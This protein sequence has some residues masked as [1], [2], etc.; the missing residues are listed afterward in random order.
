MKTGKTRYIAIRE[1][2]YCRVIDT[3]ENKLVK[4]FFNSDKY[5]FVNAVLMADELN[6][7][8]RK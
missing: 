6:K 7:V 2:N 5:A 1:I 3:L 8:T 4:I